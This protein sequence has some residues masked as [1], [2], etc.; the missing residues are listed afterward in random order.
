MATIYSLSH[1]Y[2]EFDVTF[3][4]IVDITILSSIPTK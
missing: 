4:S 2:L 1:N 3:Q